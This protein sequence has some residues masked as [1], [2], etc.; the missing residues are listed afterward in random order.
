M[1]L[2]NLDVDKTNSPG[3]RGLTTLT[4][5]SLMATASPLNALHANRSADKVPGNGLCV[6]VPK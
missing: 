5:I 2:S 4:L 1:E 6:V 3:Q